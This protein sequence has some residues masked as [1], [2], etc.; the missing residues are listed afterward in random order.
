MNLFLEAE[1]ASFSERLIKFETLIIQLMFLCSD[2]MNVSRK[3][4]YFLL[5]LYWDLS[6]GDE[7]IS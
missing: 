6:M 7:V 5:P 4:L 3:F 2:D 1:L